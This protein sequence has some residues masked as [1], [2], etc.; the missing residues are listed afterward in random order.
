MTLIVLIF[1]LSL[2]RPWA[3]FQMRKA[4]DI[5]SVVCSMVEGAQLAGEQWSLG[6][7]QLAAEESGYLEAT[8]SAAYATNI[9]AG[10]VAPAMAGLV[11]RAPGSAGDTQRRKARFLAKILYQQ[12]QL[13]NN[14]KQLVKDFGQEE[15]ESI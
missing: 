6:V 10:L 7:I 12:H 5:G 3:D 15:D 4:N 8:R 9:L 13:L 14:I 1:S 11:T 2:L